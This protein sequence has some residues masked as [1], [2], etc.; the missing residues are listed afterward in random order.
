M[1]NRCVFEDPCLYR[2]GW[3][4]PIGSGRY[5]ERRPH[6]KDELEQAIGRGLMLPDEGAGEDVDWEIG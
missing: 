3:G 6:H 1:R 4:D 5:I 2:E